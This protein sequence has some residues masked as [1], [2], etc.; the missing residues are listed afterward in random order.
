MN[1]PL[2]FSAIG[3]VIPT[4]LHLEMERSY[5]EYAMSVI[6]GRALP[7]VRDGLKPVHR[8]II[9]AMHEL[10]LTPDRPFRKCARVVGDVLGKYH[11]HG[12]QA[13]YDALV[14]MVQDFSSRYPLLAGHGNFGSVDNDPAAAMRYTE[15]RL[16]PVATEAML[17][18]I[19]EAIVDFTANFDNSQQEPTVLQAQLPFLL[20]NGCSGI[21][22]G[23]ATNIPP[24]NLGEVVDGLIALINNPQLQDEQ[25]WQFIPGPD[26]PTG[27]E[28][29]SSEG[30]QSAYLT[31][32]GLIPV[33]GVSHLETLRGEKRRRHNRKAIVI[34]ELPY[35]VNKAAWIEK[36]ASLVNEGR[37]EGIADLRDESDRTGMR[38]VMELKRDADS[39]KVLDKLYQSTALQSNFGVIFLALVD[40]KPVQL[41]LRQVLE[42]FLQF[43]EATLIRQYQTEVEERSQRLALVTGLLIALEDLDRLVSI[44]RHAADGTTAKMQLQEAFALSPLQADAILAMPLRRITGL[45]HRKLQQEQAELTERLA[46]LA[47]LLGDRQQRLKALKKELR[48]LKK[49]FSDD[50]RT[51][52]LN[53][54]PL[55]ASGPEVALAELNPEPPPLPSPVHLTLETE[56]TPAIPL[57]LFTSQPPPPK[58]LITLN[59]EGGVAWHLPEE[60]KPNG[61]EAWI[62]KE[63]LCQQDTLL[64]ITNYGKAYGVPVQSIP[65]GRLTRTPLLHLLPPAAQQSSETIISQF[66]RPISLEN[67][68]LILLTQQGR[69]KRLSWQELGEMGSRGLSLI[70][71]K[72]GDRLQ[73]AISTETDASQ[74]LGVATSS[75][76]LL[77]FRLA[78]SAIPH[79]GRSAQGQA[80]LRLR[81]GETIIGVLTCNHDLEVLL[82]TQQ[83]WGKRLALADIRLCNLGDL[84]TPVMKFL[85]KE[86]QLLALMAAE[87][88]LKP[89][90]LTSQGRM[91]SLSESQFPCAD[92]DGYGDRLLDLASGEKVIQ[93]LS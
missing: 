18:N 36:V 33:R 40:N 20:L 58:A 54:I 9:Y 49:Q 42:E 90:F 30:T 53:P 17:V 72:D 24:H 46:L 16:A 32:K 71:T 8:R 38:V 75:G 61:L 50:R 48:H 52:I 68:E 69:L 45:E 57:T 78:E 43:R 76:R 67:R 1:P 81:L 91:V 19:S 34:T 39:N 88:G 28:I 55:T 25:L 62:Y 3:Q 77:Q 22:V 6:V 13:V 60:E 89:R 23:M 84:G 73:W 51:R 85:S 14:R 66:L 37:L 59:V 26:F 93:T 64:V 31:G 29:L 27:G 47:N 12:D 80:A 7:D 2:E 92:R 79:L 44:L 15:T 83:G 5:L 63:L 65:P 10:G 21:A 74:R 11:P 82:L 35:Q 4:A 87:P 70:K 56:R 86:D 41:T